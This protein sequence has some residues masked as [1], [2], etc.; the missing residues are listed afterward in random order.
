M[1]WVTGLLVYGVIWW[2]VFF[3]TLPVGV[4]SQDES[5]VD[6]V[7]GTHSSAP[8]SPAIWRKALA[9]TVI[10]LAV[11]GL[12]YLAVTQGWLDIKGAAIKTT[13]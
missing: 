13:Y 2:L 8:V 1:G 9:T 11:W 7:P 6:I 5:D 10:A 4:R 12:F 3:M